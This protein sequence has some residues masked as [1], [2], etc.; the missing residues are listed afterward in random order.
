MKDWLYKCPLATGRSKVSPLSFTHGDAV[1]RLIAPHPVV[2]IP[3]IVG[4]FE[5]LLSL[6]WG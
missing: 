1:L 6:E 2:N 4:S 3:S 5:V